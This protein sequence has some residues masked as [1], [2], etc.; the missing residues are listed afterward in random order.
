[1]YFQLSRRHFLPGV[2]IN[3]AETSS[4]QRE[5]PNIDNSVVTNLRVHN[6]Y[7]KTLGAITGQGRDRRKQI[8]EKGF[9]SVIITADQVANSTE[10]RHTRSSVLTQVQSLSMADFIIIKKNVRG[11]HCDWT[12][13]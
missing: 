8:K 5:S 4:W 13:P 12:T 3:S 10:F 2:L 6:L 11:D 7:I 9:Q 1:M